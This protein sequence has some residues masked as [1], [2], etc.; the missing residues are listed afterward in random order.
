[1]NRTTQKRRTKTL[2]SS[3][4][5]VKAG[6]ILPSTLRGYLVSLAIGAAMTLV[7]SFA[8]YSLA[9]PNRYLLP[10][11]FCILYI[12]SLLGGFFSAKFNRGSALLCGLLNAAMLLVTMLLVSLFFGEAYSADR[13]LGLSIGL[14]GI[15][16][17]LSVL[18][19]MVATHKSSPKK[20]KRK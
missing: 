16:V 15:T 14:R 20:R 7:L 17:L 9:D 5:K 11:S 18:G 10:V 19:A 2:G 12:S 1:M 8:V 4:P 6:G 3:L 13:S